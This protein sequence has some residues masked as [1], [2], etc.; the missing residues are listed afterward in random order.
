MEEET[1]LTCTVGRT[2]REERGRARLRR[3]GRGRAVSFVGA[4]VACV[5]VLGAVPAGA[6]AQGVQ[7]MACPGSFQVEHDDRIGKLVLNEGAYRITVLDPNLLSC[8][9]ASRRFSAFLQ[10]F[11][12]KLPPPWKLNVATAT[13]T[14]GSAT[15]TG[16]R[17]QLITSGGGGGGGGNACPY[18]RVLHNDRIGKLA[19]PA[20]KY[21]IT[22]LSSAGVGCAQAAKAFAQFLQD[23]DGRLPRP[24]KLNVATATF[25]RGNAST[26]FRV[27]LA[28]GPPPKPGRS[29]VHPA[30]GGSRCGGTFQVENDDRI[31][32]LRLPAGPYLITVLKGSGLSCQAASR[33][34]RSFLNDTDGV[35][36]RPWTVVPS[37]GTFKN[38]RRP[39]FTVK[40]ARTR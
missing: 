9:S 31:G 12:G 38:G 27:K 32:R 22:L 24:W 6:G 1:V 18:F 10:D 7:A 26:G 15:T 17:V 37:S 36:P 20:G 29:G 14:R 33:R 13:F 28:V 39:G 21:R 30:T 34:F 19:L 4:L 3:R 8:A 16:F 25:T 23:F 5:G 11:D 35:L 40:P 2:V